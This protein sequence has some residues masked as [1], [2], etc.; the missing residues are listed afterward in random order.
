MRSPRDGVNAPL[1]DAVFGA[2]AMSEHA[3]QLPSVFP[4]EMGPNAMK[5]LKEVVD[6]GLASD[7]VSRMERA[8]AGAHGVRFCVGAPGCTQALFNA[9]MAM[10]F[11][12]GD[13]IIMSPIADYGT[14]VGALIE[15]YIPIFADT[16]PGTGLVSAA[17][18]E[19]HITKRTRAILVVHLLGLPCDMDPIVAL[20]RKHDLV[21]IEDVCQAI[22]ATYKGRLAGTFGDL[23]CFSFDSEKTCGADMGGATITD[24][25]EIY[26]RL[27]NR[28]PARGARE[29]PGFGRV[30][31]YRG[32]PTRMPQCTAAT[33]LAN[34]E[35]LP[36]QVAQRQRTAALLDSMLDT[37][38]GIA[39]YRVP[40]ER[41]H[42]Y[43]MYGFSIQP[44]RFRCTPDEFARQLRESG[45]PQAGLARYY[46]MPEGIG[47]LRDW[48][49]HGRYPFC[50]PPA[51]RLP[52]YSAD[53]VSNAR[54]FLETWIR[55]F[56]T[57]KY[58]DEHVQRMADIVREVAMKNRR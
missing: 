54:Q 1:P 23:A 56:W 52:R 31:M 18:I 33:V 40:P 45:I 34:F 15:G 35:I 20:A 30:H 55:W 57:E 24:N 42:T 17:T 8:I 21:L 11:E 29:V 44:E 10:D 43:W 25:E 27:K 48:V 28:G 5:Y 58:T 41:S 6:S 2:T 51:S 14:V 53:V 3:H 9:M 22:L 37:V 50:I 7:M 13:E 16:E 19:P 36:R 26:Q 47:F 32:F 4:R 39:T 38:T 49:E 12:Q 46:L